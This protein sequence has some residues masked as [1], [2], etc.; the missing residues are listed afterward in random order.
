[1]H[2]R[3][4]VNADVPRNGEYLATD[5]ERVACGPQCATLLGG[6]H[7]D[8]RDRESRDDPVAMREAM[9]MYR[10]ARWDLGDQC[11]LVRDDL[12]EMFIARRIAVI[13]PP[14]EDGDR[15]TRLERPRMRARIDTTSEPADDCEAGPREVRSEPTSDL[16]SVPGRRARAD[17]RN[18]GR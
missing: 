15:E 17:D 13:D 9:L 5:L 12:V 6:L 10:R 1:M 3:R 18:A 4:D 16:L 8:D 7:D 14:G 2:A 11:A